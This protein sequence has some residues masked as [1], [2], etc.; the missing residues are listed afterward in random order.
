MTFTVWSEKSKKYHKAQGIH[1][2]DRKKKY[3][4]YPGYMQTCDCS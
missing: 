1:I 3:E 2:L 4:V